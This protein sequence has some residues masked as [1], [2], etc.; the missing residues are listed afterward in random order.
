[1]T[2]AYS[3]VLGGSCFVLVPPPQN[4]WRTMLLNLHK[5]NELYSAVLLSSVFEMDIFPIEYEACQ[6][7]KNKWSKQIVTCPELSMSRQ[8]LICPDKDNSFPSI[9]LM[10][11]TC[12]HSL[13][14]IEPSHWLSQYQTSLQDENTENQKLFKP[15]V[16]MYIHTFQRM[17][18]HFY[19]FS[20]F[21][22]FQD[23][24]KLEP[25]GCDG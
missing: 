9:C 14:Y 20:L 10:P 19:I 12:W 7:K 18:P 2:W 15:Y 25:F 23:G 17:Q 21:H 16:C 4:L 5:R 11:W 3:Q 13:T 1:M 22:I 24:D 6:C 8:G